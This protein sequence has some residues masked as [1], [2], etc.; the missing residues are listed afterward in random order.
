FFVANLTDSATAVLQEALRNVR[1]GGPATRLAML[2]VQ[3]SAADTGPH[4]PGADIL[5]QPPRGSLQTVRIRQRFA[6]QGEIKSAQAAPRRSAD[7]DRAVK[8][9]YSVDSTLPGS[10]ISSEYILQFFKLVL[11]IGMGDSVT[12]GM[13]R[14]LLAGMQGIEKA[15]GP[16]GAQARNGSIS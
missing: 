11:Q 2:S 3:L 13:R 6:P 10:T 12:A 14:G 7:L 15:P 1:S 16:T 9:A 5:D 4:T 8:L